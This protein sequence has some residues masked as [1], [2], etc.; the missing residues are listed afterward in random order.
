M[1][2]GIVTFSRV[3]VAPAVPQQRAKAEM[4]NILQT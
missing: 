1:L 4:D 3:G 2:S